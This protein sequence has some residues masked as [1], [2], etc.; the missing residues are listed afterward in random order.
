MNRYHD[1]VAVALYWLPLT[2]ALVLLV[3]RR[4]RMP[5]AAGLALPPLAVFTACVAYYPFTSL[6]HLYLSDELRRVHYWAESLSM[7]AVWVI[8]PVAIMSDRRRGG[9][10]GR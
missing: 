5:R 6:T 3:V 1:A 2:S 4:R 8:L 10:D 7:L 9:T